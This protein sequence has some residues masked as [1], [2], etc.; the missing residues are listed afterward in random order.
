MK[1]GYNVQKVLIIIT[2]AFVPFGGLTSVM[3]NYY[4]EIDKSKFQ[5]DFASTNYDI[6]KSLLCE[7]ERYGSKY[8]C[9][10]NRKRNLLGYI[11]SLRKLF[12]HGDY[13][14]V[15]VNANSATAAIELLIAKKYG[16]KKRIA[17]NHTSICSHPIAHKI[18]YR[19]FKE[20]YTE[21]IA[22]SKKAGEWIFKDSYY[23]I[24]N[25]GIC[26]ELYQYDEKNRV[27]IRNKYNIS[28]D[29]LVVGHVGK[30]YKPK[31]HHFLLE[32]FSELMKIDSNAK[33]LLVG[34]GE[35]RNEIESDV[36]SRGIQKNVVFAGMQREVYKYLSAMD[37]FVF[38]SIWEG[39]PLS[40]I[41]AQASGLQC[42]C[43]DSIDSESDVTGKVKRLGL[44]EPSQTWASVIASCKKYDRNAESV[45]N[46]DLIKK[47]GFDSKENVLSL[48][49]IYQF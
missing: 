31:N 49:K 26:S 38:P 42:I 39:M 47:F 11:K 37:I 41:E 24:L 19:F 10:G 18:L 46:I 1:K 35:M 34:D 33:L 25:N 44:S 45:E 27:D 29:T 5:I 6:D 28:G 20:S 32:V 16:I 21:A 48:E 14:I 4:R 23:T 12:E 43:S 13:N 30:I 2:T 3:M 40:L 9:L 36:I 17:H 15:H 22:C 8:Y 7:L